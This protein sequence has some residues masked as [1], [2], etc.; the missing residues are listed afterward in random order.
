MEEPK[1]LNQVR[2]EQMTSRLQES[3]SP[4]Q[5]SITDDS[6]NHA[7][8]AGALTGK[9]HFILEIESPAFKGQSMIAV[10][11]L[12]YNA[13]GSLMDTDIHALSIKAKTTKD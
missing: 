8:H 3:L 6:H 10:H 12:I 7:G 5:L 11:R 2:I 4:T 1:S 9:G 13:L